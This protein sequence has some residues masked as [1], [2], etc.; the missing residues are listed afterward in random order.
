MNLRLVNNL[1]PYRNLILGFLLQNV[2]IVFP[3]SY[4]QF[5]SHARLFKHQRMLLHLPP[6]HLSE[7]KVEWRN[8]GKDHHQPVEP[9]SEG[10]PSSG[11]SAVS[12]AS[13]AS[14]RW[15]SNGKRISRTHSLDRYVHPE[16]APFGYCEDRFHVFGDRLFFGDLLMTRATASVE[17]I[18]SAFLFHPCSHP[19]VLR[20]PYFPCGKVKR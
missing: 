17:G 4:I 15:K 11:D 13:I 3:K 1:S 16:L 10:A 19:L 18:K 8:Q 12:T 6:R 2:V 9:E 14:V 5:L 7:R 20:E